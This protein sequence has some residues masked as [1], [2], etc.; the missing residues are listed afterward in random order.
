D[1]LPAG[2]KRTGALIP[3]GPTRPVDGAR[4]PPPS[5][6]DHGAPPTDRPLGD[7]APSAGLKGDIEEE[8]K[9]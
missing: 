8:E 4:G 1:P 9:E 6:D 5:S 7:A 2:R 3:A